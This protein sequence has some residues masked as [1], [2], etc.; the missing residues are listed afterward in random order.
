MGFVGGGICPSVPI[1]GKEKKKGVFTGKAIPKKKNHVRQNKK[2]DV[3]STKG[4]RRQETSGGESEKDG[5]GGAKGPTRAGTVPGD[6]PGQGKKKEK[7][8]PKRKEEGLKTGG[9]QNASKTR[10]PKRVAWG[11]RVCG[12]D[13]PKRNAKTSHGLGTWG[14]VIRK[15]RRNVRQAKITE[16]LTRCLS[17]KK[18]KQRRAAVSTETLYSPGVE[19]GGNRPD[20]E[21]SFRR[22]K[23]RG[24]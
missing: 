23:R 13:Q 21:K 5:E 10:R 11:C 12:A 17:D 1:T 22:R 15:T 16:N 9:R 20:V 3:A 2:L 6:T 7:K 19:G 24:D 4:K 18:W 14:V 8:N